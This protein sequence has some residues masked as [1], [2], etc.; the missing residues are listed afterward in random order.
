MLALPI[1]RLLPQIIEACRQSNRLI[2]QASPGSGKTTRVP[3]ALLDASLFESPKE[4]WVLEPRRAAAKYSAHR[5]C[6]E[7]KSRLGDEVGYQFR[8]ENKTGPKTRLKFLTE[9]IFNRLILSNPSLPQVGIVILDEFHERS[10]QTDTAL[11]YLRHLQETTRPELKLL[12]MSATL[13][14]DSLERYLQFPKVLRLESPPFPLTIEYEASNAALPLEKQVVFAVKKA[15]NSAHTKDVLVF[16]PGKRE[17][18]RALEQLGSVFSNQDLLI[19]PLHGELDSK[20][21]D[22]A[23]R[24][25]VKRKII[26]ATNVAETSLTIEGVNCVIDSGLERQADFSWWTGVHQLKTKPISKASAIQRAGRA[27]RTGPGICI[28]L[29]SQPDFDSRLAF[30]TPEIQRSDLTR[31][32]LD[33]KALG[34]LFK[35][36]FEWFQAPSPDALQAAEET[37]FFLGATQSMKGPLTVIGKRMSEIPAPPRISRF[38][39][40]AKIENC[41]ESAL[42]LSALLL[43]QRLDRTDATECLSQTHNFTEKRI[44][45]QLAG[46]FGSKTKTQEH[47]SRL[48]QALLTAF[49]DRVAQKRTHSIRTQASHQQI[50]L[51]MAA[52]GSSLAELTPFTQG[53]SFFIVLNIQEDSHH[54]NRVSRTYARSLFPI[55]ETQL[56]ENPGSFLKEFETLS[57]DKNRKKVVLKQSLSFG[58]L[59]LEENER[60]PHASPEAFVL[61][62]KEATGK[63]VKN[64]EDWHQWIDVF[65]QFG[66]KQFFEDLIGKLVTVSKEL[67]T[68]PP[69]PS[70]LFERLSQEDWEEYSLNFFSQFDWELFLSNWFLNDQMHLLSHL[71]PSVLQLPNGRKAQIHYPL[72]Q[73]PWVESRIQDFFGLRESPKLLN[74]KLPITLHLLAPNQRAIQVTQDLSGFWKNQYAS[75]RKELSRRYPKHA[76]PEDPSRPVLSHRPKNL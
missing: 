17:I 55:E 10:V 63:T 64:F 41:L 69:S 31:L 21:Q 27:A 35:D 61:F 36:T 44:H 30:T 3:S 33:A 62:L 19:L 71:A 49:P 58:N 46:F 37:L 16:L 54:T 12:V 76:W 34:Y 14:L 57:W 59:I 70:A 72:N 25:Q 43:E 65:C 4:I 66:E 39:I 13:E 24:P 29:F 9:G 47:P 68:S 22:L 32:L 60:S 5:I 1:D 52:G 26:L 8:F 53:Q 56:L 38:L 7:R 50:E 48:G 74:G 73:N 18:R 23:I 6:E 15:L 67:S 40:Q 28:R 75:V 11:S 2:L 42:H 51:V 45:D 20:E